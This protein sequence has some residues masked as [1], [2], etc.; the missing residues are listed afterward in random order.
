MNLIIIYC[1]DFDKNLGLNTTYKDFYNWLSDSLN[2][3][4]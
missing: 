2:S 1:N 4:N 3:L